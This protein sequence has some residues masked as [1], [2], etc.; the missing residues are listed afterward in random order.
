MKWWIL[1]YRLVIPEQ[2]AATGEKFLPLSKWR[3]EECCTRL[4]R[5][6]QPFKHL[7]AFR[8]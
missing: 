7:D 8:T 2:K 3:F 6:G 1:M 5:G 4:E